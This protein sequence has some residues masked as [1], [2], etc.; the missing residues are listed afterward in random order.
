M[1]AVQYFYSKNKRTSFSN[2][3]TNGCNTQKG[4]KIV[5]FMQN[6]S[7]P[8][9]LPNEQSTE[10]TSSNRPTIYNS[11]ISLLELNNTENYVD[12]SIPQEGLI[13]TTKRDF[14]LSDDL[15]NRSITDT[16]G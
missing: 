15:S 9:Q 14:S 7:K 12:D 8:Y 3:L 1:F 10:M 13:R 5:S 4:K 2:L 16:Q 6:Y 11:F